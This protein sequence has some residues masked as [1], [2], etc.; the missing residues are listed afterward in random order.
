MTGMPNVSEPDAS[1]LRLVAAWCTHGD[2]PK[3]FDAGDGEYVIQGYTV[4]STELGINVPPGESLVKV[5][6]ELF[7]R[8]EQVSAAGA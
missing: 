2:C 8:L 3:I 1:T 5:P 7:A 6:A 4:D